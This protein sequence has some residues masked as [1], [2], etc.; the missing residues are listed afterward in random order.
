MGFSTKAILIL[1]YYLPHYNRL[2]EP[3]ETKRSPFY[4]IPLVSYIKRLLFL[5]VSYNFTRNK[6][7][8]LL[9]NIHP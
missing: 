7:H 4:L 3:N 2:F 1:S 5:L 9:H 8:L 6:H